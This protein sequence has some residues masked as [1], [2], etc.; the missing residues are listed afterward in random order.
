MFWQQQTVVVAT[1]LQRCWP[2][3]VQQPFVRTLN[4]A[5]V[6]QIDLQCRGTS[7][8]LPKVS[9]LCRRM[10]SCGSQR[11]EMTPS[12][13]LHMIRHLC[14]ITKSKG[15]S[16]SMGKVLSGSPIGEPRNESV[17][18]CRKNGRAWGR[19]RSESP[20][21]FRRLP[22]TYCSTFC[23]TFYCMNDRWCQT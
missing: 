2:L 11:A 6:N 21:D 1:G 4:H 20:R 5:Y 15:C 7:H 12:G 3:Q 22:D 23:W 14:R 13:L 17:G 9:H 19:K 8:K 10:V 16:R 18:C